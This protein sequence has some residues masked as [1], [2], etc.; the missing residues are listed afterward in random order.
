MAVLSDPDRAA[1]SALMQS[2]WSNDR[3]SFAGISK[4]DLRAAIN[5]VDA[6]VDSNASAYNTAIPQPVRAA[7]TAKQKARLLIYVVKRRWEVS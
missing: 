2:D 6:W 1:L 3:E 7:L 4:A 5:A